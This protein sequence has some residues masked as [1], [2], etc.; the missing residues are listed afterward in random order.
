MAFETELQ[1]MAQHF[2]RR[3]AVAMPSISDTDG[4]Q[5]FRAVVYGEPRVIAVWPTLSIQPQR[6]TRV[7]KGTRMFELIFYIDLVL[8]HGQV[9]DTL[10]IQEKTQKRIEAVDAW[11]VAD[12]QW[13]FDDTDDVSKD[14]VMFGFPSDLDHPIII[15]PEN[16]LWAASRIRLEGQS[17]EGF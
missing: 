17:Q 13:N 6:R 8:Y 7:L 9:A 1:A 10:A 2:E 15:A 12:L 4:D 3:L 14:K 11:V 5:A 16:E